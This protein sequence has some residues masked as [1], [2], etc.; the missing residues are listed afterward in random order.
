MALGQRGF[1][2]LASISVDLRRRPGQEPVGFKT[3]SE[4]S[5]LFAQFASLYYAEDMD[6]AGIAD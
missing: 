4:R 3:M 5:E 6:Q 2:R 1:L